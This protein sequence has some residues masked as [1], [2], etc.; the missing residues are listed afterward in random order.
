MDNKPKRVGK[1]TIDFSMIE[2]EPL[3]ALLALSGMLIVRA[4]AHYDMA[5]IEYRAYCEDFDEVEQGQQIPE[6]VGEFSQQ[7]IAEDNPDDILGGKI[8][9]ISVFQRWVKV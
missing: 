8:K 5:V 6:Y 9:M 2:E 1:F 3:T 7:E 4:E